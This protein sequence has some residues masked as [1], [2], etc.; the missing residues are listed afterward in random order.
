VSTGDDSKSQESLNF[1][2]GANGALQIN[3]EDDE[4]IGN[5]SPEFA[6]NA[7]SVAIQLLE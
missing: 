4:Y 2:R 1:N 7:T 3:L 6:G 5:W